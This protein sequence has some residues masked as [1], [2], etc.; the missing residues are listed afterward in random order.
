MLSPTY[1][2]K[3]GPAV[4]L[5]PQSCGGLSGCPWPPRLR[6]WKVKTE[7]WGHTVL[8]LVHTGKVRVNPHPV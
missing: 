2:A 6:P 1:A 5:G 4:G 7:L 3:Q 8:S